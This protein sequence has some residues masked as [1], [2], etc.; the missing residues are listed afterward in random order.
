MKKLKTIIYNLKL[1]KIAKIIEK[2]KQDGRDLKYA[3]KELRSN[4]E[5]VLKAVKKWGLA[6]EFA[7]E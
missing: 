2:V 7:S 1:A 5:V 3:S 6:L 4:K